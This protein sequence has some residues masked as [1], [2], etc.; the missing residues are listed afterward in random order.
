MLGSG[1]RTKDKYCIEK[2]PHQWKKRKSRPRDE[3]REKS[4]VRNWKKGDGGISDNARFTSIDDE[5]SI[6]NQLRNLRGEI[7]SS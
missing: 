6:S 5:K 7:C 2:G 1:P 3:D 4:G